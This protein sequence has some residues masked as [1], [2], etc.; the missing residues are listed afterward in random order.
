M[1]KRSCRLSQVSSA[2]LVLIIS[3]PTSESGIVVLLNSQLRES[4]LNIVLQ[5]SDKSFA[6]RRKLLNAAALDKISNFLIKV[7]LH[8]KIRN[9]DF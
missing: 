4:F 1:A 8:G 7:S 9:D 2:E 5:V 6:S 3:Y